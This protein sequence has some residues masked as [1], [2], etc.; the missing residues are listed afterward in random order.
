MRKNG[1]PGSVSS[2]W[3]Q[4]MS[5]Y[6]RISKYESI[7]GGVNCVTRAGLDWPRGPTCFPGGAFDAEGFADVVRAGGH[8]SLGGHGEE[9]GLDT[10]WE[11]W[12][13]AFALTPMEALE[14]AT[15]HGAH[16]AG[17]EDD[18]GSIEVGKLADLLV[19]NSNPLD[20]IRNTVDLLYV[21]KGGTLYQAD[22]LDEVWPDQPPYGPLPWA[23]EGP[24]RTD[25][26]PLDVWDRD[27]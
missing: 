5:L 19:L 9:H 6:L 21:M 13:A 4:Q 1:F 22:S 12:G 25:I 11:L 23:D 14:V 27:Q 8:S 24:L 16:M 26:V 3:L 7:F 10:H 15:V 18:L 20:D 17:L 2:L